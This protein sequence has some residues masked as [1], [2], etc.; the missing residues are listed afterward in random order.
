MY[1]VNDDLIIKKSP[2]T[3]A[4][5]CAEGFG[6]CKQ[7]QSYFPACLCRGLW[8]LQATSKLLPGL[9]VQGALAVASNSKA[10]SRP[11]C[12]GALAVASNSKATS[13]PACAGALAVASNSKLK[14]FNDEVGFPHSDISG[15]KHV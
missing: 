15:S 5:A 10:T 8:L 7:Q 14:L 9:L 13:R 6:C 11:A 2:I 3:T 1:S 4:L 12:A